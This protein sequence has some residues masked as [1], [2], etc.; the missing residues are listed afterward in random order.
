MHFRSRQHEG[1]M[2]RWFFQRLEQGVEG[3]R[4]QHMC[5]IYD[6]ELGRPDRRCEVGTLNDLAY[7]VN[8]RIRCR[9]NLDKVGGYISRGGQAVRTVVARLI[10]IL[11]GAVRR[12]RK[13]ASRAYFDDAP[14]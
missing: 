7:I 14:R 3:G 11:R 6:V 12:P 1:G 9:V 4:A 13:Q 2:S 8:S 10:R 5:L